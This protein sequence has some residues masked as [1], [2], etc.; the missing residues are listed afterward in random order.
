MGNKVIEI[1][2]LAYK[3]LHN[4]DIDNWRCMLCE[5]LE[6]FSYENII[7]HLVEKHSINKNCIKEEQGGEIFLYP[8]KV[9]IKGG[10]NEQSSFVEQQL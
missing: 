7:N 1:E 10:Q 6:K 4:V 3:A 8:A 2:M 5:K 9:E